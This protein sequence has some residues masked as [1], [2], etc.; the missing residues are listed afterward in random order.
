MFQAISSGDKAE[1]LFWNV[2]LLS[3]IRVLPKLFL[4]VID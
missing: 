3:H 1:S 2:P 4:N